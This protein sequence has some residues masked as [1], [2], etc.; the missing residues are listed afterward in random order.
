[1]FKAKSQSDASQLEVQVRDRVPRTLSKQVP[2]KAIEIPVPYGV[3]GDDTYAEPVN[4]NG[5]LYGI[6]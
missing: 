1:M 6:N 5:T 4:D 2:Y 3:F